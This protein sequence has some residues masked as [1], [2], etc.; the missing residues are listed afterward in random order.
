MTY[1][2]DK[3]N[4]TF[5]VNVADGSVDTT[6]D[7]RLI[8]KNYAGYGEIENENFL[9]LLENFSNTS[10]PP[11]AILGQIW[12]DS[13]STVKKIKFWDGSQWK[14]ASGA[15][16][17]GTA[18]SGLTAGEFWFDS[19][20]SRLNVWNGSEF[21]LVGPDTTPETA[22]TNFIS[23]IVKDSTETNHTILRGTVLDNTI[24]VISK[25]E[26]EI[27]PNT[28][29]WAQGSF[30]K[31]KKGIT[32]VN[33]QST[34]GATTSDHYFWGTASAAK[35]LIGPGNTVLTHSDIVLQSSSGTF[36]DNG[37]FIG[38]S[39]DLRIWIENGS[40]PVIE[41][42]NFSD[43]SSS[44][45][46]RLKT[47][48]SGGK[49]DPLVVTRSGLVPSSTDTFTIGS[50]LL[51]WLSVHANTFNGNLIGNV[52]GTHTGTHTGNLTDSNGNIK[53]DATT[54]TFTGIFGTNVEPAVFTGSF[55]GNLNGTATSATTVGGYAFSISALV[56]TIPVRDEN[57]TIFSTRFS[58]IADKS[59]QLL[60]GATYR[61]ASTSQAANTIVAR[62]SNADITARV[63]NGTATS[64]NYADLAEKYLP[65]ADYS[66]GT[67]VSI[68]GTHEITASK[69][70]DRAIG[71]ISEFPAFMMNK[72][73]EDGVYVALKGRVPVKIIGKVKKG[74]K[75]VATNNGCATA[76][77]SYANDVFAIALASSDVETIKLVEAIIL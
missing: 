37:L 5:L 15:M 48:G 74:D 77:E 28:Y 45:V 25:D 69:H 21:I 73:L 6:T 14:S 24:I 36:L 42:Q 30:S 67:V 39:N 68:G 61:S 33:T 71:A 40:V 16:S 60:V 19:S 12:Y 7:L 52:T 26:F 58:G 47:D 57:G 2:V 76:A 38:Q 32:L 50:S 18:P 66:V 65:D 22:S 20:T 41:N 51:K 27:K 44:I 46:F 3:F 59:D 9:H 1:K 11:K 34:T 43:L 72:D 10:P 35:G 53:F 70:G 75:L 23:E 63:F 31:I 17:Q 4:G 29:Q 56:N 62:D 49:R 55:T 8:G 64:A 54:G 13:T